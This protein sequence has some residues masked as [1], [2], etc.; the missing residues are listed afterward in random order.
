MSRAPR[1]VLAAAALGTL[2]L[3]AG[4]VLVVTG[5]V[6]PVVV[7]EGSYEPLCPDGPSCGGGPWR[8]SL[9]GVQVTGGGVAALGGL[10]LAGV[11]G[12]SLGARPA[13]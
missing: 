2:L 4:V 6:D 9:S 13:G 12:W 10:L 1:T 8:T 3:V 11:A 5:A 7:Y